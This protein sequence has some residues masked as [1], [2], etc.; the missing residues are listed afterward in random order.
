MDE[1]NIKLAPT[2]TYKVCN[3]VLATHSAAFDIFG[4]TINVHRPVDDKK[5]TRIHGWQF[6]V[7][8][9]PVSYIGSQHMPRLEAVRSF[10]IRA[11]SIGEP[12]FIKAL[13]AVL[14][15]NQH[16]LDEASRSDQTA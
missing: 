8:G 12:E 10:V 11:L 13:D 2:N 4:K 3:G 7:D 9:V 5:R 14:H 15:K 16:R 1:L 6:S